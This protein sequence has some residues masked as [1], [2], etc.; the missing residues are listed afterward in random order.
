MAKPYQPKEII[1]AKKEEK[2]L[3][4]EI[5]KLSKDIAEAKKQ[6]AKWTGEDLDSMKMNLDLKKDEKKIQSD[7]GAEYKKQ[8][9]TQEFIYTKSGDHIKLII[10]K[11]N[12]EESVN[13]IVKYQSDITSDIYSILSESATVRSEILKTT[14]KEKLLSYDIASKGEEITEIK[15][16]IAK[17]SGKELEDAEKEYL[18]LEKSHVATSKIAEKMQT[19]NNLMNNLLGNIGQSVE[20]IKAMKEQ[21]I[22]FSKA[23]YKN[24]YLIALALVVA[25]VAATKKWHDMTIATR[26]SL[27]V[28]Y[29]QAQTLNKE[30]YNIDNIMAGAGKGGGSFIDRTLAGAGLSIDL[31]SEKLH[32]IDRKDHMAQL[33]NV[34]GMMADVTGKTLNSMIDLQASMGILPEH[35]AKLAKTMSG[36]SGNTMEQEMST[37]R[38]LGAWAEIEGVGAGALIADISENSEE[39]A[40]YTDGTADG[41]ARAALEA[42]K[43]GVNLST[44]AKIADSLLDF[45]SSIESEMEASLLIGKQLNYNR[46]RALALEGDIAG[47]ARDV[48]RQIGGAGAFRQLNTLQR[49]ALA[50]SVGVTVEELSRLAS[51]RPLK[52]DKPS[53]EAIAEQLKASNVDMTDA[54]TDMAGTIIAVNRTLALTNKLL[55]P[56]GKGKALGDAA[57]DATRGGA[58][59]A[60]NV[61]LKEGFE[62]LKSGNYRAIGAGGKG[63]KTMAEADAAMAKQV[64]KG[65]VKAIKWM[66]I[67][68]KNIEELSKDPTWKKS[69]ANALKKSGKM[70]KVLLKNASYVGYALDVYDVSQDVMDPTLT[71]ETKTESVVSTA[72]GWGGASIGAAQ[73]FAATS[74]IPI[75]GARVLG[76]LVGAGLGYW[77]A[78]AG[79]EEIADYFDLDFTAGE[80]T[81][82]NAA[83]AISNEFSDLSKEN[84]KLVLDQ[85]A[86]TESNTMALADLI[87]FLSSEQVTQTNRTADLIEA[88]NIVGQ[89][90]NLTAVGISDLKD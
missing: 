79:A 62:Q 84:R 44:T 51:G 49:Q 82:E 58:N 27:G 52:I 29:H 38:T 4:E 67:Y 65:T 64:S 11:K 40:K 9:K 18:L 50:G 16:R 1:A 54:L 17:L 36:I 37:L 10:S 34:S 89:N 61:A 78:S 81:D 83:N 59:K 66:E 8:K 43:M 90:T 30:L 57:A 77:F 86:L 70:S 68:G 45:E 31:L 69:I 32:G 53:D 14:S 23:L 75:P 20:G 74:W 6:G 2:R 63:F 80:L 87:K 88:I 39:L 19:Q 76:T 21:A 46:A 13:R 47:A 7:I 3:T 56:K 48:V 24:P 33:F 73:G 25:I 55:G 35:S 72:A 71:G 22:L 26:D 85:I 5:S 28:S 12:I 42:R 15:G 60:I 41:L